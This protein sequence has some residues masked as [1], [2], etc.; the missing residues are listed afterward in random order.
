MELR[1]NKFKRA[2]A[3]KKLQIGLWSSLSDG[4]SVEI[5]AGAG[6]DWILIDTEHAPNEL[7]MVCRQLQAS[8]G[9]TA[10]PVVRPPWNDTVMIKR[11]LDAGAQTLLVPMVQNEE[12]ARRAVAAAHYPPVGVRGF[13]T[14]A[15]AS[16]FGRIADY[17]NL[18]GSEICVLV[19]IETRQ[20]LANLERIAAVDGVDGLFIGP[21]DLSADLGYLGNPSHPDVLAVFDETIDRIRAC[22]VPAGFLTGNS[23]LARHVID[24]GCTFVAVGSDIGLLTQGSDLLV[25]KFK[26]AA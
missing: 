1:V 12:E 21:G 13:S 18:C 9:G 22:G 15:R 2:L 8:V 20:A 25:R 10:H 16:G 7:P 23:D 24:R 11:F 3:E 4:L 5:L 6:F 19:Q 17:F 26:P 14:S